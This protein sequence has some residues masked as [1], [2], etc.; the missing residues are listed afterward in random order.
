MVA[1]PLDRENVNWAVQIE[2]AKSMLDRNG[3]SFQTTRGRSKAE[4]SSV[5]D[6]AKGF[7]VAIRCTGEIEKSEEVVHAGASARRKRR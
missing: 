1:P 3:I 7:T 4:P 6:L 2:A 5:A